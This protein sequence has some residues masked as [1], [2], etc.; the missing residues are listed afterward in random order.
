MAM[1]N[2]PE[3][4]TRISDQAPSC[5]H[6]GIIF[7]EKSISVTDP[8]N[9]EKFFTH[10]WQRYTLA[11]FFLTIF[12]GIALCFLVMS[13]LYR[14]H[15][16]FFLENVKIM[17]WTGAFWCILSILYALFNYKRLNK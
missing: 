1:I 2:C 7:Q 5:P 3:C 11:G 12:G 10:L 17:V 6:C 15:T 9:T 8:K 13:Y 16:G 14:N 4:G